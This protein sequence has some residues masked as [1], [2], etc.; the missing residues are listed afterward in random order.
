[1]KLA[2]L[3]MAVSLGPYDEEHP[4][5]IDVIRDYV[6]S[7]FPPQHLRTVRSLSLF[8]FSIAGC[9]GREHELIEQYMEVSL[10]FDNQNARRCAYLE[11]LMALPSYGSAF[12]HGQVERP[13]PK[14]FHRF[15]LPTLPDIPVLVAVSR[16]FVSVIDPAKHEL[17]L[18]QSIFDCS[19]RRIDCSSPTESPMSHTVDGNGRR[20]NLATKRHSQTLLPSF[21]LH[22]PDETIATTVTEQK[23]WQ[24]LEKRVEQGNT[25]GAVT[26]I[27]TPPSRLLQVFSRQAV[28]IEA[29]LNGLYESSMAEMDSAEDLEEEIEM[30]DDGNGTTPILRMES[31]INQTQE[32]GHVNESFDPIRENSNANLQEEQLSRAMSE[33]VVDTQN[34][35]RKPKVIPGPAVAQI[36]ASKLCLATFDSLGHCVDAQGSLRRV[37]QECN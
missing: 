21:L 4:I 11:M 22:F 7:S 24:E 36:Y 23:S 14:H 34:S 27:K 20:R 9:R 12:F 8:G 26:D 3:D 25:K 6:A 5:D 15:F 32:N 29:L 30:T 31:E 10:K 35:W 17:L 16:S 19:W 1:M 13:P 33:L 37:L 18:V 2:A 28:M